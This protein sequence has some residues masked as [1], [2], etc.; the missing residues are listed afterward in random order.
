MDSTEISVI[1]SLNGKC[2]KYA[3]HARDGDG[4]H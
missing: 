3:N 2:M 4:V 1:M